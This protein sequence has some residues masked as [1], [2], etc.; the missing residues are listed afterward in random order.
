MSLSLYSSN[1]KRRNQVGME[2]FVKPNPVSTGTDV[3]LL[4]RISARD[5]LAVSELYDK[6]S[7][8]LFSLV[9]RIVRQQAEAEDLLQEIFLRVWDKAH[10]YD[11]ALSTPVVWLTRIARNI[12]I[13]QLRSKRG[14]IRKIEEDIDLH[15]DLSKDEFATN[16]ERFTEIAQQREHVT[17]AMAHLPKEQRDL[18][19]N[20]YFQGFTQ[21]EL[22]ERFD[23]PL[24]TV[25]TRIRTG[26]M[27]L[28]RHLNY[29][30]SG[31]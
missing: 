5:Q 23:L 12:A 26:M 28:R 1:P 6:Y 20:A 8:L 30:A 11:E 9:L 16:P 29:M 3:S 4:R 2:G 13:D 15:Q 14:Q 27:E 24:G 25:K 21:A 7:D 10:L 17:R 22:A 19:E 18:I 31:G